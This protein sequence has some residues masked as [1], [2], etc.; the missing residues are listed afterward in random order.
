MLPKTKV[1]SGSGG[2]RRFTEKGRLRPDQI[3][4]DAALLGR[5]LLDDPPYLGSGKASAVTCQPATVLVRD[6]AGQIADGFAS[7]RQS[8]AIDIPQPQPRIGARSSAENAK[9]RRQRR[10]DK[11]S[12]RDGE[13]EGSVAKI[14]GSQR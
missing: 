1:K 9:G 4:V 10:E 3:R 7:A 13:A 12:D 6:Q 5:Q 14:G 11:D 2:L 8:S